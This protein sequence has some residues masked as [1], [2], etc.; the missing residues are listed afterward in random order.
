MKNETIDLNDGRSL[1]KGAFV[2]LSP[3]CETCPPQEG[4]LP[5]GSMFADEKDYISGIFL[6]L[7]PEGM[8]LCLVNGQLAEYAAS[9][10]VTDGSSKK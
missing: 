4:D 3:L 1:E 6:G 7:N 2:R 8:F 9:T 10:I 5:H